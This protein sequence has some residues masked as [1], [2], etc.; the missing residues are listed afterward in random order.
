MNNNADLFED[1]ELLKE[2]Q[3]LS[4]ER[5]KVLSDN[6]EVAIGSSNY[7]KSDLIE[8]V[9]SADS[10]GKEIM[11]IQLEFL[12]DLASGEFYKNDNPYNT[13]KSR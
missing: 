4:V 13:S 11:A 3:K 8:H 1:K 9:Q 2:L 12:Q 5:L 7:S 6:T 10:V